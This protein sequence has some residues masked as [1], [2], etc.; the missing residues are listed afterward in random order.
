[1]LSEEYIRREKRTAELYERY[2]DSRPGMKEET[3][4]LFTLLKEKKLHP[5]SSEKELLKSG[6]NT[7]K[8]L[9]RS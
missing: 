9:T 5:M 3:D 2:F 8:H 1:M 7:I 6:K 4:E